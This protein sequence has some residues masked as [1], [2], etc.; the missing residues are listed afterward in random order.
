MTGTVVDMQAAV[1]TRERSRERRKRE[2]TRMIY[3][4]S[5]TESSSREVSVTGFKRLLTFISIFGL[6]RGACFLL[7]RGRGFLGSD[8]HHHHHH[9]HRC[10]DCGWCSQFSQH[11]GS[12]PFSSSS[13][14]LI[15]AE[16]WCFVVAFSPLRFSG[17]CC[18]TAGSRSYLNNL[19][20][21]ARAGFKTQHLR[22][23]LNPFV[24]NEQQ[25]KL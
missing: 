7:L 10:E 2:A 21:H 15:K 3:L 18:C 17:C 22:R 20:G 6:T 25:H 4:P 14:A 13:L 8:P 9:H 24:L 19:S 1:G 23:D 5:G 11:C 16:R 12:S